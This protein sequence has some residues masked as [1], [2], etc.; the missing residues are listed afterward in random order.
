MDILEIL[1]AYGELISITLIPFILWFLGIKFQDRKAKQDAKLDLFLKLMANRKSTPNKDWADSL[2]L[3]DVI[4]QD[5]KKVRKAWLDY[6][7]SLHPKSAHADTRNS[8]LLDLLSEIANNLNYR[9]LKQTEIDRFYSPQHFGNQAYTQDV[10][11]KETIRV[12][13]RTRAYGLELSE[14]DYQQNQDV[15][16]N[17][18][19][20]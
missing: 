19:P 11:L 3:I 1:R 10:L 14:D 7:D 13:G 2:N 9:D 12:L 6:F 5:D 8:F 15:L 20:I 16:Y 4:F 17:N 18:N